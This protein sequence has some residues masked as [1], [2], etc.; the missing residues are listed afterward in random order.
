MITDY[1]FSIIQLSPTIFTQVF[2]VMGLDPKN[3]RIPTAAPEYV[4]FPFVFSLLSSKETVQYSNVLQAID[5]AATEYGIGNC[6]PQKIMGDFEKA[7]INACADTYPETAYSGC[8]Y[9]FCQSLYRKIQ[10]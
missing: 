6:K 5:A 1:S 9:H 4:T 8:F 2:T 3:P 10:S 7:V